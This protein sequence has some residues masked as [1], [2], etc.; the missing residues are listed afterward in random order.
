ML[1][2]VQPGS[3]SGGML[4]SVR[5]S[6]GL[7]R[8][9]QPAVTFGWPLVV[10][11]CTGQ[12]GTQQVLLGGGGL[13]EVFA[14]MAGEVLEV[15][16]VAGDLQNKA[17][18]VRVVRESLCIMRCA[19]HSIHLLARNWLTGKQRLCALMLEFVPPIVVIET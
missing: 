12:E 3:T 16:N 14:Q 5:L 2:Y 10:W 13:Q 8:A 6:H 1:L 4:C 11:A 15:S 18:C 9:G 19:L 17:R 7:C